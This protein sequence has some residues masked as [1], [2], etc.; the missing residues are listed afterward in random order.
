MQIYILIALIGG[1]IAALTVIFL[2][3]INDKGEEE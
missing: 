3:F 1:I 2:S